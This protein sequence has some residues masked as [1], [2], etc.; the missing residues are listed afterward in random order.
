VQLS[1]GAEPDHNGG[2]SGFRS[3][4][5]FTPGWGIGVVI[6]TNNHRSPNLAGIRLLYQ[7]ARIAHLIR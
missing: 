2:T 4:T 1:A 5:A 7:A 6:L 3:F